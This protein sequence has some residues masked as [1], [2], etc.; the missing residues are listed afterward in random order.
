VQTNALV[1]FVKLHQITQ[2]RTEGGMEAQ[3][4]GRRIAEGGRKFPAM[5][6]VLSLLHHIVLPKDLR[7]RHGDVNLVSCPRGVI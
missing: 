6:Q 2:G 4:S 7:F 3:C 5:S 1:W